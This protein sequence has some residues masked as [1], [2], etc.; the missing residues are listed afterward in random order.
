MAPAQEAKKA[1]TGSEQVLAQSDIFYTDTQQ[2]T[3][4]GTIFE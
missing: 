2:D 4:A 1:N 3:G